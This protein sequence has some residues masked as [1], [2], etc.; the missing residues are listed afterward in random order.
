[1][2]TETFFFPLHGRIAAEKYNLKNS[3]IFSRIKS[4]GKHLKFTDQPV[5][6]TLQMLWSNH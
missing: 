4:V 5:G 6:K 2:S 3:P 1:M